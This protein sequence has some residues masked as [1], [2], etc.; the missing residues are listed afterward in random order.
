MKYKQ[1]HLSAVLLL[2][3]FLSG[4]QGQESVNALGG[5]AWGSGGSS[6]YSIG[7]V[8]YATNIGTNGSILQGVQQPFEISVLTGIREA[9]GINLSVSVYPNPTTDYL[10]LEIKEFDLSNVSFKLYDMSGKLLQT[11]K[12]KGSQTSIVMSNLVTAIYFLKVFQER[13]EVKTFK[14]MKH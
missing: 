4:L 11:E 12:L 5:N 1:I 3:L 6:S 14:I 10:N 13:N 9:I 7:Q 8:G 2:F